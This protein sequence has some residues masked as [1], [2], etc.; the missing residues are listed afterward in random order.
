MI[1]TASLYKNKYVPDPVNLHRDS[2]LRNVLYD[3]R[4]SVSNVSLNEC[5]NNKLIDYVRFLPFLKKKNNNTCM[6]S[7]NNQDKGTKSVLEILY[8]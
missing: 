1:E 2:K 4:N 5:L 7:I 8:G 6:L 3:K